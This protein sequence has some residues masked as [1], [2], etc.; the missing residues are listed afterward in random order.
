[1]TSATRYWIV[2]ETFARQYLP[3]RPVGFQFPWNRRD[4]EIHSRDTGRRRRRSE[5][6][7]R[8]E[9]AAR[10]VHARA[11][12]RAVFG[13]LRDR[14]ANGREPGVAG[15]GGTQ[16][17]LR[18]LA[19]TASIETTNVVAPARAVGRSAAIRD[20]RSDRASPCSSLAL[21]AIGLSRGALVCGL[22]SV[23]ASL[24][25]GRHSARADAPSSCWW[26]V[27]EC[28]W[29]ARRRDRPGGRGPDY[30]LDAG[31]PFRRRHRSTPR[32]S[33]QRP[34]FCWRLRARVPRS[35]TSRGRN[36][37]GRSLTPRIMKHARG[38]RRARLESRRGPT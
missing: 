26:C 29:P 11:R 5:G 28:F 22:R 3:P 18:T 33:R 17:V 34:R 38:R 25:S 37:P 31:R 35:C 16:C 7:Q 4:T 21:A 12:R 8:R 1:M 13:S 10:N 6:R 19:P 27:R 24:A 30:A 2:N 20:D 14:A 32:R 23:A 9:A 15:A 36:G